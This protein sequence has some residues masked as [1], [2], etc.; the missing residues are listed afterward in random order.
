LVSW[1]VVDETREKIGKYR[2]K[3]G[4]FGEFLG[5]TG[6]GKAR[7]LYSLKLRGP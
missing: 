3:A 5:F 4:K 2:R 6:K 1:P 7:G